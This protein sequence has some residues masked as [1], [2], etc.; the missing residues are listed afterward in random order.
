MTRSYRNRRS[1]G[2]RPSIIKI[3]NQNKYFRYGPEVSNNPP[4]I[5]CKHFFG[6]TSNR[7]AVVKTFSLR[8]K[9]NKLPRNMNTVLNLMMKI[10]IILKKLK[11]YYSLKK[12]FVDDNIFKWSNVSML[13]TCMAEVFKMR[14]TDV[15]IDDIKYI[16]EVY[17]LVLEHYPKLNYIKESIFNGAVNGLSCFGP[18]LKKDWSGTERE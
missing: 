14:P 13:M 15:S 7:D 10:Y 11:V 3:R 9:K 16:K 2:N 4:I 8:F 6:F 1:Y 12:V 17:L 5:G 18:F